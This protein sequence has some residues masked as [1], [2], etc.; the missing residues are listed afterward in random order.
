MTEEEYKDLLG[1]IDWYAQTR[2]Q[3]DYLTGILNT[4]KQENNR[5]KEELAKMTSVADHQQSCN[6][7]RHFKL[8]QAKEIIKNII[9]VTWGEGWNYSLDVKVKAEQFLKEHTLSL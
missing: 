3:N 8:E 7:K 6:M 9:R 2:E 1:F 4:I 5:L